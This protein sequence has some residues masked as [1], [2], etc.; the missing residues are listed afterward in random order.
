MMIRMNIGSDCMCKAGPARKVP[1]FVGSIKEVEIW[2]T[3]G[4]TVAQLSEH[5]TIWND[6]I[7]P[8][9]AGQA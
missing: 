6:W 9:K 3:D 4:G 5:W 2:C 7:G 8:R 1:T